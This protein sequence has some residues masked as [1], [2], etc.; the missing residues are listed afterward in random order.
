MASRYLEYASPG[1][2]S[3]RLSRSIGIAN[4][5]VR[6]AAVSC[7]IRVFG[8]NGARHSKGELRGER[9]RTS[10]PWRT[11]R[12][13]VV[14]TC[15]CANKIVTSQ[16][17]VHCRFDEMRNFEFSA[18]DEIAKSE[19][20]SRKTLSVVV[21][22]NNYRFSFIATHADYVGHKFISEQNCETIYY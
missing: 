4:V 16:T 1:S 2:W 12:E 3:T 14:T 10:K 9:S 5:A 8:G 6:D 17:V 19:Q 18:L 15:L 13:L 11:R 22:T 20:S 21:E 7:F